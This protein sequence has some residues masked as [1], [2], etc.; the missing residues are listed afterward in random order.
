MCAFTYFVL[1]EC[2][3]VWLHTVLWKGCA[4]EYSAPAVVGVGVGGRAA[5]TIVC[6]MSFHDFGYK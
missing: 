2:I 6:M 5:L 4:L 1:C 3:D